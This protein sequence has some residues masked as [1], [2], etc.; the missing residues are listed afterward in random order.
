MAEIAELH[1]HYRDQ[2]LHFADLE[3]PASDFSEYHATNRAANEQLLQKLTVEASRD[4]NDWTDTTDKLQLTNDDK[5]KLGALAL[6]TGKSPSDLIQD[7]VIYLYWAAVNLRDE[8]NPE[9]GNLTSS[10]HAM[11]R[12]IPTA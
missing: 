11:E 7:S 9:T 12:W 5:L 4:L 2:G 1:G 8:P 3:R 6:Y 10:V